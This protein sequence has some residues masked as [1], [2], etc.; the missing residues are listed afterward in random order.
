MESPKTTETKRRT[1][2]ADALARVAATAARETESHSAAPRSSRRKA[3][4][5]SVPIKLWVS[6]E[7]YA[8]LQM[9]AEQ[10]EWSVPQVIR[11]VVKNAI[12]E[13]KLG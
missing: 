7:M 8:A 1:P 9:A 2:R 13:Q 10:R 11:R 12:G 3:A 5:F 4:E 6:E